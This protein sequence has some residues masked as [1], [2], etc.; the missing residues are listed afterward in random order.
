MRLKQ[1]RAIAPVLRGAALAVTVGLAAP[2]AF[3]VTPD[4]MLKDP[5]M[6]ARAREIS[7]VLRCVVCQNQSIDDSNAPLAQDLRILVRDRLKAGDSNAA[8]IDFIVERYGNFV[9]LKP[10]MQTNTLLLWFGPAIFLLIAGFAFMRFFRKPG[11]APAAER[12]A[13]LTA[14]ERRRV[15][16]LMNEGNAS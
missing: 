8:A 10:P 12:T 4:E 7:Q 3:A 5:A 15:E 1:G 14:D 2:A 6:E 13:E 9:L 11:T 16:A